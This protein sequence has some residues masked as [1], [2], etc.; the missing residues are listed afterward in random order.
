[1]SGCLFRQGRYSGLYEYLPPSITLLCTQ[2]GVPRAPGRVRC[3][4][5]A[6]ILVAIPYPTIS[7][8]IISS[9]LI[10]DLIKQAL[11][12]ARRALQ[13]E[14]AAFHLVAPVPVARAVRCRE[15]ECHDAM[16][17]NGVAAQRARSTD[18]CFDSWCVLCARPS[19]Q[20]DSESWTSASW[21]RKSFV[22][23]RSGGRGPGRLRLG[24]ISL[25]SSTQPQ[26]HKLRRFC[27][28]LPSTSP[29]SSSPCPLG[30]RPSRWQHVR[31]G[32]V[33]P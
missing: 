24:R 1:M 25:Q 26:R 21:R 18:R 29:H 12:V 5:T 28:T 30:T 20:P 23:A 14:M 31:P 19:N 17:A 10:S 32:Q 6:I 2:Y 27:S 15:Q 11:L 33:R 22:V 9:R 8:S 4:W 3:N 16:Y 13:P 7:T